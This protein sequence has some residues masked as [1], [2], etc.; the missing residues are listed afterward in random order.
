M[1]RAKADDFPSFQDRKKRKKKKSEDIPETTD[2]DD[3]EGA[4]KILTKIEL[5][6]SRRKI[7]GESGVGEA[8]C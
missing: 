6:N 4:T 7:L 1:H 5:E 3:L 8:G 2:E